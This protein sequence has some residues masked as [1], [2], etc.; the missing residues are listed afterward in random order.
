MSTITYDQQNN[1]LHYV[2]ENTEY[3]SNCLYN[4]LVH[5]P[6]DICKLIST[7]HY[8]GFM[9]D[10][11]KNYAAVDGT[12]IS[13][14]GGYIDFKEVTYKGLLWI[15][16]TRYGWYLSNRQINIPTILEDNRYNVGRSIYGLNKYIEQKSKINNYFTEYYKISEFG[17][18]TV[19][20]SDNAIIETTLYNTYTYQIT[21]LDHTLFEY[22]MEIFKHILKNN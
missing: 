20:I 4:I 1:T 8:N 9:V 13:I 10:V 21:I 18:S 19:K 12:E 6:L 16:H 2:R 7:Y 3:I 15:A 14:D 11:Q 17:S 5:F 22:L